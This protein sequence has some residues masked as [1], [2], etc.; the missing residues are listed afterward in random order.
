MSSMHYNVCRPRRGR[1]GPVGTS[2]S[3]CSPA[4]GGRHSAK[5]WSVA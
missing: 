1:R 2:G 4:R 3:A 5:S